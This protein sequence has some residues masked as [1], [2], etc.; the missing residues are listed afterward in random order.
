MKKLYLLVLVSAIAYTSPAQT[1]GINENKERKQGLFRQL[2]DTIPV[3]LSSLQ[4]LLRLQAGSE[5]TMELSRSQQH[6][7]QG[8]VVAS[9][10]Q[11]NGQRQAVSVRT[12]GNEGAVFHISKVVLEDGKEMYRGTWMHR[13]YNEIYV[14][15]HTGKE[16]VLLKK[17]FKDLVME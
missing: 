10:D 6:P 2:P 15:T 11:Q 13:D 8:T 4:A 16:Y 17:K 14:L 9:S 5:V 3:E 7:I 1:V 12:P